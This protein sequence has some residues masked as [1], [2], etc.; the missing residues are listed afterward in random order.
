MISIGEYLGFFL[1]LM[2]GF[3]ISFELPVVCF[4]LAKMD[5]IT[6]K[7]LIEF[8]RYAIIIIFI[9]ASLLTPPDIVTQFLMAIPLITLYGF[10]I[11][12]V[13]AVNPHKEEVSE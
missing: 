11:L 6:E 1:R 2:I 3:G 8:F 5:L 7:T 9:F 12:I 4:F 10:S 13:K